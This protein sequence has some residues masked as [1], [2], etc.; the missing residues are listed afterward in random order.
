MTESLAQIAPLYNKNLENPG[1]SPKNGHLLVKSS[2]VDFL[3]K[4]KDTTNDL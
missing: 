3:H 4:Y 1:S 2:C